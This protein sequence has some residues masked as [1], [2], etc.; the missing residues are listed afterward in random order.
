[1]QSIGFNSKQKRSSEQQ[2]NVVQYLALPTE[3]KEITA[4]A[5]GSFG[6]RNRYLAKRQVLRTI[7]RIRRESTQA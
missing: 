3:P 7:R 4:A 5:R 1:M 2:K 6:F